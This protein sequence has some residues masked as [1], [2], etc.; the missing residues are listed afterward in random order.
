MIDLVYSDGGKWTPGR[1]VALPRENDK[2]IAQ[3]VE[4]IVESVVQDI[5]RGRVE[6]FLYPP[7]MPEKPAQQE[8]KPPKKKKRVA[9]KRST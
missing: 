9:R 8:E 3:G 2:V 4:Y 1:A 5:S 6:V 7:E